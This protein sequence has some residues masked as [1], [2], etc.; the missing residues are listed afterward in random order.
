MIGII[1]LLW[2][3]SDEKDEEVVAIGS[4]SEFKNLFDMHVVAIGVI[5]IGFLYVFLV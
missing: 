1:I 5:M 4:I 3:S 2:C